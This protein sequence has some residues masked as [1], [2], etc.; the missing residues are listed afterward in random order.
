VAFAVGL[1]TGYLLFGGQ[2]E[3]VEVTKVAITP[4]ALFEGL[5]LTADQEAAVDSILGAMRSSTDSLMDEARLD[6][7]GRAL[8]ARAAIERVLTPEQAARLE[9]R[10]ETLGPTM[11]RRVRVND[12][13]IR[14]DTIP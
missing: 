5:D 13:L 1:G 2:P 4:P 12:S 10:F 6:L 7:T 9:E 8:R 3:D 11:V 14:V